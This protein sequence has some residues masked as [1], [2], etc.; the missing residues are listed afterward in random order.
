VA[1][2]ETKKEAIMMTIQVVIGLVTFLLGYMLNNIQETIKENNERAI[3]EVRELEWRIEQK[4]NIERA[5]IEKIRDYMY[6]NAKEG[7]VK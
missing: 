5:S 7:K 6:V 3:Q 1:D 4:L 2:R